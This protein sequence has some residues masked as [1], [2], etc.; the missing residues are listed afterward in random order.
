[1]ECVAP[2]SIGKPICMVQIR[3]VKKSVSEKKKKQT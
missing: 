3:G 2:G 1:M